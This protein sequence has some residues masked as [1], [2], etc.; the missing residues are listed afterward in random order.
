MDQSILP[1]PIAITRDDTGRFL[2]VFK[3]KALSAACKGHW[4]L[5]GGK[6]QFGE[7]VKDNI[8]RKMQ[9]Y[10]GL[11]VAV[12]EIL[13][14]IPPV[15]ISRDSDGD[16][17]FVIIPVTVKIVSGELTLM[18]GK[19]KEARWFTLQELEELWNQGTLVD[20]D[21]DVIKF[22]TAQQDEN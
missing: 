19:I 1:I 6:M 20:K 10:L 13:P 7:S 16:Y 11:D 2:L 15:V 4:Q 3:E 17:E 5:P 21:M 9:E 22:V 12:Q 18:E 14:M 8:I